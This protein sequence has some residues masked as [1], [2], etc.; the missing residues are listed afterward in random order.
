MS[1]YEVLCQETT[2]NTTGT[3]VG[4]GFREKTFPPQ[5]PTLSYIR[6]LLLN[7][8]GMTASTRNLK[9]QNINHMGG[10]GADTHCEPSRID[11][12]RLQ[13]VES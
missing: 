7:Q 13:F 9:S 10:L 12:F 3:N 4:I 11:R 2:S 6:V 1:T 5:F 8:T